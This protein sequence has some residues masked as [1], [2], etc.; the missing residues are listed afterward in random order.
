M[1]TD[2]IQQLLFYT[3]EQI[4]RFLTC[5][6]VRSQSKY[7]YLAEFRVSKSPG[8]NLH[9][10]QRAKLPN[11]LFVARTRIF[12]ANR[13]RLRGLRSPT[14]VDREKNAVNRRLPIRNRENPPLHATTTTRV[15]RPRMAMQSAVKEALAS[16]IARGMNP[17]GVHRA[18]TIGASVRARRTVC[19]AADAEGGAAESPSEDARTV[20]AR[21]PPLRTYYADW[22]EVMLPDGHRFP[23]EKYQATRMVLEEDK[24]LTDIMELVPSP[25]SNI[26]I[27]FP[28]GTATC[29]PPR[30]PPRSRPEYPE[31]PPRR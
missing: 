8:P 18:R 5:I 2:L 13:S 27:P 17:R 10:R 26:R 4:V 21:P 30:Y 9:G 23:M 12:T 7:G 19:A 29:D 14:G 28:A 24:S 6:C 11:W 1:F 31:R 16:A 3:N 25:V 15:A 20:P 22:A